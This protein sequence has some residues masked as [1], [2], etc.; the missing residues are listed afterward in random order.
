MAVMYQQKSL[1]S[2]FQ[3]GMLKLDHPKEHQ[4]PM[5]SIRKSKFEEQS[6]NLQIQ[7]GTKEEPAT[8]DW[9]G[10]Q[11]L[12]N[13][14]KKR[15]CYATKTKQHCADRIDH[16]RLWGRNEPTNDQSAT[17]T[18]S[19]TATANQHHRGSSSTMADCRSNERSASATTN[20]DSSSRCCR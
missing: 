3:T 5:R 16:Q 12:I 8:F 6:R 2:P 7:K 18:A 20:A 11:C 13:L 4:L 9:C 1:F 14:T 15:G 10:P 17:T 19:T